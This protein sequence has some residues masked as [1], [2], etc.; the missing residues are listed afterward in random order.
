M[1]NQPK[2]VLSCSNLENLLE[3]I[4]HELWPWNLP[5]YPCQVEPYAIKVSFLKLNKVSPRTLSTQ[6]KAVDHIM[7]GPEWCLEVLTLPP[8]SY[9]LKYS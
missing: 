1:K 7:V 5:F 8:L 2:I 3:P 4:V 9:V 6:P